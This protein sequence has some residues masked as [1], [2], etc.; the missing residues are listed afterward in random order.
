MYHIYYPLFYS[1]SREFPSVVIIGWWE[2]QRK[3]LFYNTGCDYNS[4]SNLSYRNSGW[5]SVVRNTK[6]VSKC[7]FNLILETDTRSAGKY[8]CTCTNKNGVP[9]FWN[10]PRIIDISASIWLEICWVNE[11]ILCGLGQKYFEM[12]QISNKSKKSTTNRIY[13]WWFFRFPD[14]TRSRIAVFPYLFTLFL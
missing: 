13:C 11:S 9:W 1:F 8:T 4:N 12:L 3:W 7:D 5:C 6:T 14:C 2:R 10:V